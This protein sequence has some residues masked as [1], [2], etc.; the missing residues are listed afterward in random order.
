MNLS[1][2]WKREYLKNLYLNMVNP[3]ALLIMQMA[4]ENIKL[5]NGR[6]G[7]ARNVVGLWENNI[8]HVDATRENVIFVQGAVR[9]LTGT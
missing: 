7:Y 3:E 1:L 8:Y 4:L 9:L 5:K 2:S 6:I